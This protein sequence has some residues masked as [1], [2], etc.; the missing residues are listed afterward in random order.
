L[1]VHSPKRPFPGVEGNV[2]LGDDRLK[3]MIGKLFLAKRASEETS[4]VF[5]RLNINDECAL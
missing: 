3:A 5:S 4:N 1:K 2:G